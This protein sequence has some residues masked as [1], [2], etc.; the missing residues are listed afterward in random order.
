MEDYIG[1]YSLFILCH[2][3]TGARPTGF[4]FENNIG[5]W[6]FSNDLKFCAK[7][8]KGW[9]SRSV[10]EKNHLSDYGKGDR[11]SSGIHKVTAIK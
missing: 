11:I 6:H 5:I 1:I 2:I 3:S 9:S 7:R 10:P 4:N 8:P